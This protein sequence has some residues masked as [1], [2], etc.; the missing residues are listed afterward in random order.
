F[1]SETSSNSFMNID[2]INDDQSYTNKTSSTSF[3]I[4]EYNSSESIEYVNKFSDSSE[5]SVNNN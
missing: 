3:K 2:F 5:S 1:E 4:D